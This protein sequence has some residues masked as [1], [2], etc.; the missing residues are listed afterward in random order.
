[1]RRGQH[2]DHLLTEFS[3]YYITAQSHMERGI[4]RLFEVALRPEELSSIRWRG[5]APEL[6]LQQARPWE[7]QL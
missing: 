4:C 7:R 1:M 5:D 6:P 2:L 3:A